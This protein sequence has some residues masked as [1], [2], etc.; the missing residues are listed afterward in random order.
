MTPTQKYAAKTTIKGVGKAE[1]FKEQISEGI[2]SSRE[3]SPVIMKEPN[4]Q[5]ETVTHAKEKLG[6]W[7]DVIHSASVRRKKSWED[8][9]ELQDEITGKILESGA[10]IWDNY[11]I[12]KFQMLGLNWNM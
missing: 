6:E 12:S 9:V 3:A 7:L 10:S 4:I 1:Q 8:E 11:D 5:I 2:N